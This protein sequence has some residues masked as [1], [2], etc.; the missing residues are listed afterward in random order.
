M[1]DFSFEVYLMLVYNTFDLEAHVLVY[2]TFGTKKQAHM[3]SLCINSEEIL[4][5]D[6]IKY[7]LYIGKKT[8]CLL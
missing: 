2:N 6:V 3:A 7:E 1:L 4:I 5:V 8:F